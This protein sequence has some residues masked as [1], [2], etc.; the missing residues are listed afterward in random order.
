[1]STNVSR[2][3][4]PPGQQTLTSQ[5][6]LDAMERMLWD[7]AFEIERDEIREAWGER[8]GVTRPAPAGVGPF[9]EGSG[10]WS[11][12]PARVLVAC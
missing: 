5:A 2:S 7:Q 9:F 12:A 10:G 4:S 6:L 8:G 3:N 1:M 11:W